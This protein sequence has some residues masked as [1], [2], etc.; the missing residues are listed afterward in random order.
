MKTTAYTSDR[1]SE[2]SDWMNHGNQLQGRS[3]GPQAE[4]A[5]AGTGGIDLLKGPVFAGGMPV[6]A[7]LTIGQPNDKYEQEADRVAEQ[8]MGMPD[9]KPALQREELP[10]E[11][12]E[13]QMKPV[14]QR[15]ELPEDEEELQMKP[16][17]QREGLP[18]EELQMKLVI[19][20]EELPEEEELQ[21]KP[22]IQ[23]EELPEEEEE[24]QMKPVI[25]REELPKEEEELQMKPVIQREELPEEEELQMK[26]VI[27]R[28]ELPEELQMKADS[29]D[30]GSVATGALEERLSSS[31]GGGSPLSA[32]VRS[33][34]EPRFG[35]DFSGVR[36]HTGGEAVQMN[37]EVGAQA[38]AYGRD[39]Y[40]G[41]G[42]GPGKDALTAHELTHVV[43]QTGGIRT[44]S[45]VTQD[46]IRR[47]PISQSIAITQKTTPGVIQRT[48]TL[49]NL[50]LSTF[51]ELASW[52]NLHA[53]QLSSQQTEMDTDGV[54]APVSIKAA[55]DAAKQN[56]QTCLTKG[57]SEIDTGAA[58]SAQA[59]FDY[60]YV[61]AMNEA[62]SE[63]AKVAAKRMEAAEAKAQAAQAHLDNVLL[64]K[65]RDAQR[66]SF[67]SSDESGLLSI[68]DTI[69]TVID[70]SL[71]TKDTVLA[72][73][74]ERA[75]LENMVNVAK[76]YKGVFPSANSKAPAILE[77][78][79]KANKVYAAFQLV[80]TGLD[81]ISSKKTASGGGHAGVRAMS[82]IVSA[83]GTLLNASAGM[84]VY[85]NL[86]LGPMVD[87][88][89]TMLTKLEDLLSKTKNRQWIELGEFDTVN[90]SIEPGGRPVFN[91]MLAV[92]KASDP[93]AVPNPIPK[94]VAQYFVDN[95]GSFNAGIGGKNKMP[96][97]GFWFL[98]NVDQTKISG[99]V[100]RHRQDLWAM[101]YG[102]VKAP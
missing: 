5:K 14:I 97:T 65:L 92:I 24:L 96:T 86:Y 20:R 50:S 100:F 25:Q 68:A 15:E 54:P 71:I 30:Q 27:Q 82:S 81:L 38:F 85:A 79:E 22:V 39:V 99:W 2:S 32:D 40:F 72:M 56:Q 31:K 90:W 74:A 8:V 64:P 66:A 21:M 29:S 11:E 94:V 57:T 7:K 23:R 53:L 101:L 12:E 36:V 48:I 18:E 51:S 1:S 102:D 84:T 33:F 88:C 55:I 75:A 62:E 45:S 95:E 42:K 44:S 52:Y 59:W 10:E 80:R 41:A 83:G 37:R 93:S 73:T 3:F 19:Q 13:L 63:K 69:A 43:Q 9:A 76:G 4:Q 47:A 26:P 91:F 46:I 34:M 70:T 87:A 78:L 6:R 35:A 77:V 61:K 16:L 49:N 58:L 60:K 17:I 98:E 89:L 28:E 67:R